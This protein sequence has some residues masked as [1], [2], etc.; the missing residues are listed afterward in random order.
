[1]LNLRS[2]LVAVMLLA[3]PIQALAQVADG[4]S[5]L[6]ELV[7]RDGSRVYGIIERESDAEVVLRTQSGATVTARREDIASL[8]LIKGR[9]E[10]G[11]FMRPDLHRTRLWLND[12]SCLRLR[13]ECRDPR[14]VGAEPG[15]GPAK[16]DAAGSVVR[17]VLRLGA[18]LPVGTVEQQVVVENVV[19][20]V[21]VVRQHGF[22]HRILARDD[23]GF[24]GRVHGQRDARE[25]WSAV[26]EHDDRAGCSRLPQA[27][28]ARR[29]ER[30]ASRRTS[31]RRTAAEIEPMMETQSYAI[32]PL[33]GGRRK[34]V[35]L[36][37]EPLR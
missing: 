33:T 34:I 14:R 21:D 11:E 35:G 19:Q 29:S 22:Q 5:E 3:V 8:R 6:Y 4:P 16:L 36:A 30:S 23:L 13:P 31:S 26:G 15:V 27:S 24:Q 2:L 9:I 25:Q 17:Q 28:G 20:Q 7:L 12:G 18:G 10:R 37:A 1:M 32:S